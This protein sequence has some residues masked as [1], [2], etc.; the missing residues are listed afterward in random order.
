VLAVGGICTVFVIGW[1]IGVVAGRAMEVLEET[2]LGPDI[3]VVV[4]SVVGLLEEVELPVDV[5]VVMGS[6]V[7][8]LEEIEPK[9]EVFTALI[10]EPPTGCPEAAAPIWTGLVAVA[11]GPVP[12]GLTAGVKPFAVVC[13]C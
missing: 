8:V 2:E 5:V 7:D 6:A 3:V 9:I 11:P 12:L 1:V 10:F 4:S 13:T